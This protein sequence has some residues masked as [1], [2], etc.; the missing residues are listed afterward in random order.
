MQDNI[1]VENWRGHDI[2]FIE[3]NGY[4]WAILK[5]VCDAFGLKTW[6]ISQQLDPDML[7][8]V[9]VGAEVPSKHVDSQTFWMF[10]INET[11]IYEVLFMRRPESWLRRLDRAS[12][13]L[14]I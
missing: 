7:E 1:H 11:G 8:R 5:D 2:R 14:G 10:A 9:K 6:R 13:R 3:R 4:W 12:M